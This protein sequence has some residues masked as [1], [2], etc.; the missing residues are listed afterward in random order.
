MALESLPPFEASIEFF[1]TPSGADYTYEP[2][3][4][5]PDEELAKRR[6]ILALCQHVATALRYLFSKDELERKRNRPKI[7]FAQAEKGIVLEST[8]QEALKDYFAAVSLDANQFGKILR[9]ISPDLKGMNLPDVPA[10]VVFSIDDPL[11]PDGEGDAHGLARGYPK[12]LE[13]CQVT[14][15]GSRALLINNLP[16]RA[17]LVD[18][19]GSGA[20]EVRW[21]FVMDIDSK[22]K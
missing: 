17:S 11:D 9:K 18:K 15:T 4:A 7:F 22:A 13:T 16:A 21:S 2:D 20:I 3:P 5:N 1:F 6:N 8:V 10:D 14:C 12:N 19:N